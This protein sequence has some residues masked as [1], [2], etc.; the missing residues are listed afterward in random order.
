M[1]DLKNQNPFWFVVL[2]VW[3]CGFVAQGME[4]SGVRCVVLFCIR[5]FLIDLAS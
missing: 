2:K 3:A 1:S 4:Y 5:A